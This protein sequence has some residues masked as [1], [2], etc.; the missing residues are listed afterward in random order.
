MSDSI[1]DR[2]DLDF[3]KRMENDE[4]PKKNRTI[5]F[6]TIPNKLH[7][8]SLTRAY[9]TKTRTF[10]HQHCPIGSN[11]VLGDTMSIRMVLLCD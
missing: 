2:Y 6:G 4:L 3:E 7:V 10:A 11:E 1:C 5:K 8:R 9:V